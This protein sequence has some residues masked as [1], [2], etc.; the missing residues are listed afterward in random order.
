MITDLVYNTHSICEKISKCTKFAHHKLTCGCGGDLG[1]VT[2][3][4]TAA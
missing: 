1:G 4:N 3:R 2:A